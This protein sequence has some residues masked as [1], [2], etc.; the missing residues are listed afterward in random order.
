MVAG[1]RELLEMKI[2]LIG[3]VRFE[4]TTSSSST[5]PL[6]QEAGGLYPLHIIYPGAKTLLRQ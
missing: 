6:P 2:R 4:L 5:G 1:Y 3:E